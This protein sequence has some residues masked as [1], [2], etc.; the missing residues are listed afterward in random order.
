M[1]KHSHPKTI[2]FTTMSLY[3]TKFWEAIS[4]YLN[5]AELK[6]VIICFD[7]ESARY[8]QRQKTK[9]FV[10]VDYRSL[11]FSDTDIK[12]PKYSRAL[13]YSP[14]ITNHEQ[15][16]FGGKSNILE[17]KFVEFFNSLANYFETELSN[18]REIVVVQELGGF[19]PVMATY[20]AARELSIRHLFIEPSFFRGYSLI[21]ENSYLINESV[22]G[23]ADLNVSEQVRGYI[24]DTLKTSQISIPTK[25]QHQYQQ[26]LKKV[27]NVKNIVRLLEKLYLRHIKGYRFGF[28]NIFQ[29]AG[30]HLQ[31]LLNSY[32][33]NFI[34]TN[35][36]HTAPYVYYPLHVPGD[37]AL[38]LRSPKN[39]NQ[40]LLVEHLSRC[41]PHGYKL[42]I[43]EHPAK[44]GAS[45]FIQM[46]SLLRRRKN[47]LLLDG[48]KNNFDILKNASLVISV[49]S[50]SGAEALL[51]KRPLIVLGNA[52][53]KNFPG[54]LFVSNLDNLPNKINKALKT[55]WPGNS[56]GNTQ[57]NK[58]LQCFEQHLRRSIPAELYLLTKSNC[59]IFAGEL[60]KC[61]KSPSY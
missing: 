37:I 60:S 31:M 38:T 1:K 26:A 16:N 6:P 32:L 35:D 51:L 17:A 5:L 20:L 13:G 48:T 34:Y 44:I 15:F 50:K 58:I 2:I 42:V 21:V 12:R 39:T 43:K 61:L 47:I 46:Y 49:N 9:H 25:D 14:L 7:D 28:Q 55:S 4:L 57:D 24:A 36:L 59:R 33:F 22:K 52:F 18:N 40:L 10:I 11:L 56:E 27:V 8:L 54:A 3:Q 30:K 23:A 41:I 19:L 53:Y 45:S 29:H